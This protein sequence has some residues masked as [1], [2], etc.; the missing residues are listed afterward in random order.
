MLTIFL[1][2]LVFLLMA[3]LG[4]AAHGFLFQESDGVPDRQW[5]VYQ[6]RYD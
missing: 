3:I 2:L 5:E 6:Q 4:I 1:V